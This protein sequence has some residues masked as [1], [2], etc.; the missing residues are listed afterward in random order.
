MKIGIRPSWAVAGLIFR[1]IK[2]LSSNGKLSKFFVIKKFVGQTWTES[3]SNA[4]KQNFTRCS[5]QSVSRRAPA[6]QEDK[7]LKILP[8]NYL[9]QIPFNWSCTRKSSM[10]GEARNLS[11]IKKAKK[12][13]GDGLCW[14]SGRRGFQAMFSHCFKIWPEIS[15]LKS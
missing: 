15:R 4:K 2:F 11:L 1:S 7:M 5:R 10:K 8:K 6:N 9:D 13:H 3:P 14:L 12:S